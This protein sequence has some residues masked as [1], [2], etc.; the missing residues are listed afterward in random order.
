MKRI[1]YVATSDV[2]LNTFHVPYLEWLAQ[3]G[4]AVDIVAERR[5]GLSFEPVR[6]AYWLPFPRSLALPEFV[7]TYRHLRSIIEQGNYDLIHCHTPIPSALTRL[8]ARGW[9]RRGGKV[10]YTAHG[11]HFYRGAPVKRWLVYYPIEH[12]LSAFTDAILTI[13]REDHGYAKR[14]MRGRDAFLLPGIGVRDDRFQPVTSTERQ[15]LRRDLGFA[16]DAFI[17]LYTAEF[18]PRKNHRFLV[19]AV[20]QLVQSIPNLQLV[21]AGTGTLFDEMKADVEHRGLTSYVRFL[22]FRTDIDKIAAIA[23][24]GVSSS[25]HEGLGLGLLEQMLCGA[26]VV[27]S[28]DKGHREFVEHGVTGFSFAQGDE[29]GFIDGVRKLHADNDLRMAL[30][31]TARERALRFSIANA[32]EAHRPIYEKYLNG[33]DDGRSS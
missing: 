27:A 14:M 23:D 3:A 17:L 4:Y 31:T 2:H 13:N 8:A 18:I 29:Q 30:G 12:M 11:F 9:R 24:V 15:S 6:N 32:L 16:Q 25:R 20:P 33:H 21:F 7:R 26:P 28:E 1:L 5:K 19:D 10:L 22:G